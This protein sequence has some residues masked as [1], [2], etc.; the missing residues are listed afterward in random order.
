MRKQRTVSREA[1]ML[2]LRKPT[3]M[4]ARKRRKMMEEKMRR[5][6]RKAQMKR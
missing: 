4:E 1:K 3:L 6:R 5:W 2:R